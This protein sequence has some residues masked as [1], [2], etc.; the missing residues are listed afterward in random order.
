LAKKDK[1]ILEY[2]RFKLQFGHIYT[3]KSSYVSFS[4]A[5]KEDILKL[6]EIFNGR[7][8]LNKRQI[9]FTKWIESCNAYYKMSMQPIQLKPFMTV[10]EMTTYV[11]SSS[12]LTGFIDAEGCFMLA[13]LVKVNYHSIAHRFSLKQ[14]EERNFLEM[15]SKI[16]YPEASEGKT[17]VY[18]KTQVME[19]KGLCTCEDLAFSSTISGK[20]TNKDKY[21]FLISYLSKH[22]LLSH[23]RYAYEVW[24]RAYYF[25]REDLHLTEEGFKELL[26]L[27]ETLTQVNKTTPRPEKQKDKPH[28]N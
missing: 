10:D 21:P 25:K 5:K 7:I 8:L 23:K 26:N 4:V 17:Y 27:T 2:I 11:Q 9:Q 28:T 18:T 24:L 19:V 12:W 20:D 6:V 1:C 3:F 14:S 22:H 13:P 15:L 16:L